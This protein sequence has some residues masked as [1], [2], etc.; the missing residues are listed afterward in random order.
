MYRI[1]IECE[2]YGVCAIG[3]RPAEYW[4]EGGM[5]VTFTEYDVAMEY[6][7]QLNLVAARPSR[8]GFVRRTYTVERVK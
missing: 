8:C 4:T 1:R 2:I 6:A 7:E 5:P 3:E